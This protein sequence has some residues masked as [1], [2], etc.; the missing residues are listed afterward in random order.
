M[1]CI[2][3]FEGTITFV[4]ALLLRTKSSVIIDERLA[5]EVTPL[6]SFDVQRDR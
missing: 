2:A 6:S 3:N 4:Q 1:E 5:L